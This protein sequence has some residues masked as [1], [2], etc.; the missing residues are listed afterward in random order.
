METT[1]GPL[2]S[3]VFNYELWMMKENEHPPRSYKYDSSSLDGKTDSTV[4]F[5][6]PLC[7]NYY[8]MNVM[9]DKKRK[10][11]ED[12]KS[13]NCRPHLL[14]NVFN[15]ELGMMK[16][17]CH[18][19]KKKCTIDPMGSSS[20]K[21]NVAP[22][23]SC[24]F[25]QAISPI[26][27]SEVSSQ[28]EILLSNVCRFKEPPT[29]TPVQRSPLSCLSTNHNCPV[30]KKRSIVES[31]S[32]SS[33]LS[34]LS[35]VSKTI[36]SRSL[37]TVRV[38]EKIVGIGQNLDFE[39]KDFKESSHNNFEDIEFST[40]LHMD[41]PDVDCP[42]DHE[43]EENVNWGSYE[44]QINAEEVHK[45]KRGKKTRKRTLISMKE[46]YSYKFQVRMNEAEAA[47]R[48]F[49][50]NI[51]Y[52]STSVQRLSFHL[53]GNKSCTF[54]SNESLDKVV[55]RE[56]MK[57][58]QLEAFSLLNTIDTT[59]RQY[60]YDE[61][62]QHY[63]W[64]DSDNVWNMRKRGKQIGRLFYTHHSTG[65][66]WYL[67]L[68][69]T[70]V[71]GPTS[72][73]CLRTVNGKVYPNFQEACKAYGLLDDDNEWHQV[74]QQCSASGF[75]PQIRQLFVHIMVNCRVTD[76]R[77]L[78]DAHC[79]DMID[80][81]LMIRRKQLKRPHLLLNEKQLEYYALAGLYF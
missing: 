66:L 26:S 81:I 15:Y 25:R 27:G 61:I 7:E 78:W 55:A 42:S 18:T 67:R 19:D 57:C 68:L 43:N 74:L 58:S 21:E 45:K 75:A 79:K 9:D 69:L 60:T 36:P 13:R 12:S 39:M 37:K 14:Y 2:L 65:E 77:K 71:R 32:P 44:T 80:D 29:C 31:I 38:P 3:D 28:S 10:F 54:K 30:N 49:G 51:H 50:F 59:A 40:I 11:R 22:I 72:F 41:V 64:N 35:T 16:E 23:P 48:I 4:Q 46:Y 8:N 53:P 17:N 76:L 5:T 6:D 47:Y 24:K 73:Q 56:R 52:R 20:M 70:K 62:P 1:S 63:V 34:T 33:P